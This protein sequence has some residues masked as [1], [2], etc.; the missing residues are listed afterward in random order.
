MR[1]DNAGNVGIGTS[2]FTSGSRLAV[3]TTAGKWEVIADGGSS[4]TLKNGGSLTIDS[5]STHNFN[6]GA[7]TFMKID[8]SGNVGI[9][10]SSPAYRLDVKAAT[11]VTRIQSTT[12][13]NEAYL[14]VNN[15]G[16]DLY[17]GRDN[18]A[19]SAFGGSAYAAILYSSG[20]YPMQF[21]TNATER[22]RIASDGKVGIGTSNP[23]YT[24]QIADGGANVS[25]GGTPTSNGTGRFKFI[26]SNA[27]INWQISTNDSV[28]GAFEFTPS[29]AN[30]GS[31]F[32]TPAMLINSSGNVGIGTSSPANT[33]GR[34]LTI[35]G[36]EPVLVLN[37]SSNRSYSI[38]SGGNF[39]F[40]PSSLVFYDNTAN[41]QRMR[42]DSG[43]ELI[44][45]GSTAQKATGTT[46]SNPSD[47]RL[48][49]N[50]EDY[51]KG[52]PELMQVKVKTWE[53]NGKGGTTEG[54]KG[55]GVVA[56]EI[57]EVLPDTVDNYKAKL[58]A[59]DAED[60]EIKKF[61]ATEITWLML[62]SIQEQQALIENLT[63]RLNALENK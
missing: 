47:V 60:T 27:T 21:Y 11:A 45:I 51:A 44:L 56:D 10:T 35:G 34:N 24:L 43:G 55:L 20:A 28:G 5:A 2:T 22:M 39:S 54:T 48:K 41:A 50:I 49:N 14:N 30:G 58:N 1:I 17:V 16:G 18:S 31:T 62:K 9:G 32:T 7:T 36:V 13:T 59:D 61:D 63:T 15:T 3:Q 8:A 19:G 53:Y 57:K 38:A 42:I 33:A 52:L 37:A 4:V 12:G 6:Q 26:N 25:I 23:L 29:T 46:W 40:T